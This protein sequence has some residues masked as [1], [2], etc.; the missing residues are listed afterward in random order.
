MAI[1]ANQ[2]V[3]VKPRILKGTGSDLVFNGLV[4]DLNSV[5]PTASPISFASAEDV[6][7]YF[8]TESKEYEFAT[9]YFGGYNNSQIKPSALYFYKLCPNGAAPFVRGATL[10]PAVA[11]VNIKAVTAGDIT[12]TLNGTTYTATG[13]DL[14]GITSLSEAGN[15]VANALNTAIGAESGSEDGVTITYSSVNNT[16]TLT[17][18]SVGEEASVTQPTGTVAD[19]LGL[20]DET[21]VISAG[22]KVMTA[23]DTMAEITDKFQNFVT[24]TTLDEPSDADAMLLAKWATA[25]YNA[26]TM[27]M[28]VCWDSSKANLDALSTTVISELLQEEEVTATCVCYPDAEKAAFIMGTAASIAWDQRQGT[29]TFKFK[30]QSGVSAD[31]QET[32][33]ATALDAHKVNYMGNWATR[34]DN[35]VFLAEGRILGEWDWIDTY[36]GACWLCNAAQVKL[37]VMFTEARRIPYTE[38]GYAQVRANIRDIMERAIFNGV[39]DAGVRL[40]NGVKSQLTTELGAD[41]SEEIYNNGYYLQ[42]EDATPAIRQARTTPSCN[43]VYTYGGAIHKL[44]LPAIAVV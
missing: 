37:M 4:L 11:L 22:A 10:K 13:I 28:F 35:F 12:V 25:Q 2:I 41:Y 26:G 39:V 8:G 7:D 16:Y 17:S 20:S 5:I 42:I 6:G 29:L 23:T 18:A 14:S 24:F 30:A 43:L 33:Q 15:I 19:V 38:V 21:A 40:D 36:L 44:V 1:S 3:L 32:A 34:N 27:Y 31:I 9:V